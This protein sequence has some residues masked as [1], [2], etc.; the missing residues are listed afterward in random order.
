[1][2]FHT[3]AHREQSADRRPSQG[4][5]ES[6]GRHPSST[7]ADKFQQR[8][9]APC[10]SAGHI[11]IIYRVSRPLQ[12]FRADRARYPSNAWVTHRALWALAAYRFAQASTQ[13]GWRFVR[14]L[15]G[16]I[17]LAAR[18]CTNIEIPTVARIGPGLRFGH[19]G[20]IVI[21]E[22]AT[23]GRD[24]NMS[25]GVVLGSHRN[26]APSVGDRVRFGAYAV[27][28]G[29]VTIGDDAV[30]GAMSLV[31]N[32]VPEGAVVAGIPA[33]IIRSRLP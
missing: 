7:A 12:D 30:V 14:P 10:G 5:R 11:G 4:R 19:A 15:S 8:I 32:N 3:G 22:N 26:G 24:C 33:R 9:D 2:T 27:A 16:L 20:P 17:T 6:S 1:V 18:T 31:L 23:I 28:L 13:P 21:H 29:G 25:V